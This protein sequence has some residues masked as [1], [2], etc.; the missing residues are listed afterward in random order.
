[1]ANYGTNNFPSGVCEMSKSDKP[2]NQL[3]REELIDTATRSGRH[4]GIIEAASA[5]IDRGIDPRSQR[6]VD[7]I[8]AAFPAADQHE[9]EAAAEFAAKAWIEHLQGDLVK[10]GML[11]RTDEIRNGWPVYTRHPR[12]EMLRETNGWTFDEAWEFAMRN[13]LQ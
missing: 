7:L 6:M 13:P 12:I 1:V 8:R 2:H 5:A 9:I 10:K 11:I 4:A 3:S